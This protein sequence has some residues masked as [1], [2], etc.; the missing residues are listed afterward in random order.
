MVEGGS[1][2]LLALAARPLSL[3]GFGSPL[4]YPVME[5]TCYSLHIGARAGMDIYH[6]VAEYTCLGYY[7]P[8][9]DSEL[10]EI[11]ELMG[12]YSPPCLILSHHSIASP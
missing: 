7:K 10:T 12:V 3:V 5:W 11:R 4:F 1:L 2:V 9:I 8:R 6:S